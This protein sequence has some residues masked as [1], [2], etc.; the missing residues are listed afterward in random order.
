[1][2]DRALTLVEHPDVR[3]E[4][5]GRFKLLV[6]D[7]F[8]DTSPVQLALFVRLHELAGR[9]TWVGDRKQCIFEYAGADPELMEAVTKWAR[10]AGG[11]VEQL[12]YNWRSRPEL[13]AWSNAVFSAALHRH[14]YT[15]EEVCTASERPSPPELNA[16]PP[17][18]FWALKSK[19]VDDDAIALAE[20][21]RQLLADPKATPVLDRATEQVRVLRAGDIAILVA[22]NAEAERLAEALAP[23]GVRAAIARAGL[24]ATPEGML[25]TAALRCLLEPGNALSVA[26]I[27]ALTG[28]RGLTPDTWLNQRLA[29]ET[30]RRA[31]RSAGEAAPATE[32]GEFVAKLEALR[33]EVQCLAPTEAVDRVLACLDLASLCRRWPDPN[34][35]LANLDALRALAANYEERSAQ[36]REAAT[37]AGLLR[38]FDEAAQKVLV[39]DE[40]LASD[41]QHTSTGPDAVNIVTYHRAK[42]LEWPVVILASLLREPKRG[43]FEVSPETDRATFDPE[44][45]LGGRW[46]RYWPWPFGQLKTSRLKNTAAVSPEGSAI[47]AREERER[48]RLLYVGFTRARDH[49]IL[50]ARSSGEGYK[51]A[52]LDELQDEAGVP[53]LSFPSVS[54]MTT[55]HLEIVVGAG[56][57]ALPVPTRCWSLS[58]SAPIRA[59]NPETARTWFASGNSPAGQRLPYWIAPSRATTEWPNLALPLPGDIVS[60]G[61]R[62]PLGAGSRPDWDIVGNAVHAFLAADLPELTAPERVARATRLLSAA[63]LLGVLAPQ[64]LLQ[65]GD[66]LQTWI[67]SRWPT[68]T[69]QREV[70]I[71]AII[72]ARTG[73][74]RVSGTIDLL[75]ELPEGVVLIDHKSYPGGR[76]TWQAKAAEFAPQFAAY[77]EA[78]R[79]AGKPVLEH[80]VSFAIAGGAVRMVGGDPVKVT[81]SLG[82]QT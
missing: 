21:V 29:H 65:A 52:W 8:Q 67:H 19:N 14:G 81:P 63:D 27:E 61:S 58:P 64:S 12:P 38:F 57:N 42:G 13:V 31:A 44:D 79:L 26:Q 35:R 50:A 73:N 11:S 69:W 74:R 34:Q 49:L 75:L 46:I 3:A 4:L 78:L 20:G 18:G 33:V 37:V 28:F 60:T 25:T 32:T 70:P 53:L 17:V 41:D 76:D 72:A 43:P 9:S 68:A 62:L 22:T 40:E 55:A 51:T 24:L 82:D 77:A 36:N 10:A 15:Q 71:A 16:L 23:R 54:Q 56:P 66:N 5:S 1:M 80:W 6:V 59:E 2:L 47:A 30:Q 45:P 7:E 48:V 39:R